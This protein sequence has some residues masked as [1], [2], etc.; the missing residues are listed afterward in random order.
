MSLLSTSPVYS[1]LCLVWCVKDPTPFMMIL[2]G[3]FDLE[4]LCCANESV[5]FKL[6]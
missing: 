5:W 4:S 2:S 3:E 6:L 1:G